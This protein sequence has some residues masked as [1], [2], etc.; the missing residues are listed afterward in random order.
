MGLSVIGQQFLL[1]GR[2]PSSS[3][4]PESAVREP[5]TWKSVSIQGQA[6]P[7][8]LGGWLYFFFFLSCEIIQVLVGL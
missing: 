1:G 2:T 3:N 5:E 4:E 7:A 8:R 6:G